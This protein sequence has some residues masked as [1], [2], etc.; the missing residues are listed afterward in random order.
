MTFENCK[1]SNKLISF[2]KFQRSKSM[3]HSPDSR[4]INPR[5]TPRRARTKENLRT[6]LMLIVVCVLFLLTEFPQCVLLIFSIYSPKFYE[7]VYTPMG[8]L[9]D[10]IALANNSINF[11]L[12]CTMSKAF[13]DTFYKIMSK[14]MCCLDLSKSQATSKTKKNKKAS[15]KCALRNIKENEN[16]ILMEETA[17]IKVSKQPNSNENSNEMVWD[18]FKFKSFETI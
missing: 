12:Y 8:D 17:Y 18:I 5:K 6:T 11:L 16:D 14:Y 13:R 7:E 15:K 9:I 10:I 2:K 4:P 3:V 1:N